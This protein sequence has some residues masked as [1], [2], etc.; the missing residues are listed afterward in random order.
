LLTAQDRL[1]C[2]RGSNLLVDGRA[3]RYAGNIATSLLIELIPLVRARA[4][5]GG[6]VG[7]STKGRNDTNPIAS[8]QAI[9]LA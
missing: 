7:S 5:E 9:S 4:T 3:A 6:E 1:G 8:S 2:L